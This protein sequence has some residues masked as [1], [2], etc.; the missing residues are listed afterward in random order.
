MGRG[1]NRGRSVGMEERKFGLCWGGGKGVIFCYLTSV[2]PPP[3]FYL[4]ST[5]AGCI[6]W[7]Q[8]ME[9]GKRSGTVK[10]ERGER[11]GV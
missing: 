9:K 11:D 8:G 7:L 5:L 10:R 1:R 2:S 4:S 3:F 6:D